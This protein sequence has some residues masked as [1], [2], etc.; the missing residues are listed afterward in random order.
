MNPVQAL[1]PWTS[2]I[3][4]KK[5]A[6]S[7]AQAI[8]AWSKATQ[9]ALAPERTV[10]GRGVRELLSATFTCALKSSEELWLLDDVYPVYWEL[11]KHSKAT[12]RPFATL[13]QPNWN[14]L[15]Q[16][17]E[18]ASIVLPVPL[19]PLGRLPTEAEANALFRWLSGSPQRLLIIDAVYTFDFNAARR[20]TD[21]FLSG[22]GD[23]CIVLWSCAKTWLSPRS[24]GLAAV[25]PSLAPTLQKH[26][27]APAEADLRR[28]NAV[29]EDRPDLCQLQQ[30]A[31]D[32]EWQRLAPHILRATP[33]WQPPPS[34]Y[35]SVVSAPFLTL[36]N[37]HGI[38]S[39]PASVFGSRH[40]H[41]SIVTCL[42]DLAAHEKGAH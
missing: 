7:G 24:L 22:H 15:T 33:N 41:L 29:L 25:P 14:F 4:E 5:V 31:F 18:R 6:A 9:I 20:F 23:Q 42:H 1:S 26:V 36:L 13:P 39:V 32:R 19:S 27:P 17:A 2:T 10:V 21:L 8:L 12:T 40:D 37:H 3:P 38:L 28:I 34:G 30:E 16:T 35:F 11:A